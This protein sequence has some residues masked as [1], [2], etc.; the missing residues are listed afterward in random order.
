[1]ASPIQKLKEFVTSDG[2]DP[3]QPYRCNACG[4]EFVSAKEP[5]RAQCP[6][7]LDNDVSPSRSP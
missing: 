5:E 3:R 2:G 7:C 4:E 6:E 1:M